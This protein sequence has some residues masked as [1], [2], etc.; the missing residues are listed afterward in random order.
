VLVP[1]AQCAQGVARGRR[2]AAGLRRA[3][4]DRARSSC[5]RTTAARAVC[6]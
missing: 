6:T 3:P 4:R 1:L 5:R 2:D